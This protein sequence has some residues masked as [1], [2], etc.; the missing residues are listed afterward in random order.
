IPFLLMASYS[1]R[2]G[3]SNGSVY[4][5]KLPP[6]TDETML[7]EYFGTIGLLKVEAVLVHQENHGNKMETGCVPIQGL[8]YDIGVSERHGGEK[9]KDRYRDFNERESSKNRERDGSE[10]ERRR[11]R[12]RDRERER[13][14]ERGRVSDR[15]YGYER[16]RERG[17][18]RHRDW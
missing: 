10:R 17:R 16:G 2:G 13:E 9:S 6:G 18:D 11:S 3:P 1:G 8:W 5:C 14:K 15:D 4:V 7:A 12:S